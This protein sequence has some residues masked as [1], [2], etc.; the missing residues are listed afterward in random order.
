[1]EN[2]IDDNG[3]LKVER[4]IGPETLSEVYHSVR[5]GQALPERGHIVLTDG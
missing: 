5:T 4:H 1:M 2:F 3:W